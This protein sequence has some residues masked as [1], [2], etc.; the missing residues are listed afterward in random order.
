M[1]PSW[2]WLAD[3]VAAKP[4]P[5]FPHE[6]DVWA[7]IDFGSNFQLFLEAGTQG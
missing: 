6:N 2:K 4:F 7:G 3:H 1:S 5:E